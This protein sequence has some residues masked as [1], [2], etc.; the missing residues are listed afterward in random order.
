ML[1]KLK[2]LLGIKDDSKDAI[3]EF[4]LDRVEEIIKNYCNITEIPEELNTTVLSMAMDYIDLKTL[5]MKK[6]KGS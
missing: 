5:A 2:L 6:E 4:T 3:L 1:D